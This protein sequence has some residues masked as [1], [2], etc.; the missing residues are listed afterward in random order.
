MNRIVEPDYEIGP[1]G[2]LGHGRIGRA[3]VLIPG[4]AGHDRRHGGKGGP[5]L[6]LQRR[7]G[8]HSGQER[9]GKINAR[10]DVIS[11]RQAGFESERKQIA[12]PDIISLAGNLV[13][14]RSQSPRGAWRT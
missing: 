5:L 6:E 3:G 14:A 12:G 7:R 13:G 9:A 10:N 1:D 11:A 8:S 2:L 4:G